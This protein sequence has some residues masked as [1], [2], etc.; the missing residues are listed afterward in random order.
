MTLRE[1]RYIKQGDLLEVDQD[2][3]HEIDTIINYLIESKKNGATHIRIY[4]QG[5][6]DNNWM[7]VTLCPYV[8]NINQQ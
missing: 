7:N 6:N 1:Q 8:A 5:E 2:D 4:L 3:K